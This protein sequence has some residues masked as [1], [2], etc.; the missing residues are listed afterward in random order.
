MLDTRG[1]NVK[2]YVKVENFGTKN[3]IVD[4]LDVE[5]GLILGDILQKLSQLRTTDAIGAVNNEIA[6]D[7]AA[8]QGTNKS[9][10]QLLIVPSLADLTIR[11]WGALGIGSTNQVV[12]LRGSQELVVDKLG[13]G[14]LQSI[15]KGSNKLVAGRTGVTAIDNLS[16]SAEIDLKV[17]SE[18]VVNGS[19]FI[20]AAGVNQGGRMALPV[21]L[22]H[23][24][25]RVN[26]LDT[27]ISCRIVTGC[28][29]DT[30]SLTAKL[31]TAQRGQKTDPEGDGLQQI[32]FHAKASS[33]I[34]VLLAISERDQ[35]MLGRG[36]LDVLVDGSHVC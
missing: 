34:G 28:D 18:L 15:G 16:R 9:L 8:P 31:A 27:I 6:L 25:H 29:H 7:T 30:D 26:D 11:E 13:V 23:V 35:R 36:G 5:A 20:I 33:A 22:E 1:I 24:P 19:E 12:Q 3:I 21:L 10:G 4:N 14:S 17:H 2:T 32:G